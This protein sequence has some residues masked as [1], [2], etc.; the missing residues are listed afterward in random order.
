MAFDDYKDLIHR[1]FRCGFCKLTY[2]YSHVGFNCPMY[3]RSRLESY[4][5][6]GMMWL[7]RGSLIQGDIEWSDHL[8]EILYS[9][10]MCGNCVEQCRFEFRKDLVNIFNSVR[11]VIV[12][13]Q[14]PLP[15]MVAQFLENVYLYGNPYRELR[16]TRANWAEGM[17]LRR[18]EK[19][20]D[21]LYYVG[22]V[23]SYDSYGQ[24]AARALGKL[25]LRSGLSFGILGEREECDGNEV[26]MLG[27]QALFELQRDK[28]VQMF[29]DLGVRKIVTLSPHSYN[30]IKRYYPQEFEVYH[31]TQLLR[32]LIHEGKLKMSGS[33]KAR[34]TYHDP[35]F[36]CRHN[37]EFDAPRQ[38]LGV[39]PG[40]D[41]VEMERIGKN[42]FC[43]G[44][45]GG[46]FY[47]GISA[48]GK[49]QASV[50][51]VMEALDTGASVLA[52]ACPIC[53]LMFEDAIKAEELDERL[54]VKDISELVLENLA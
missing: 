48:K 41:L 6:G 1:C 24:K 42:A 23:A 35:C 9:C 20:D 16:E 39:I 22:C 4:S 30:A 49:G 12:N 40:V 25:L 3:H 17:G 27:E 52:V 31:Y 43:C 53:R 10:A 5:P 13:T 34:V 51:R 38:V 44:G 29:K 7:I 50:A 14:L 54:A 33:G 26:K 28:N 32:D 11:E 36:L 37:D 47:T 45:G 21:V 15:P 2:D 19:G 18:Y 46:N 8:S